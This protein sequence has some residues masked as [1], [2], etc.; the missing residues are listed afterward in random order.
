MIRSPCSRRMSQ[1]FDYP[2]VCVF[3]SQLF[4]SSIVLFLFNIFISRNW[5]SL[6]FCFCDLVPSCLLQAIY[7]I[8]ISPWQ[9][10]TS[11]ICW[12]FVSIAVF[13]VK[14]LLL[15]MWVE[16]T[17]FQSNP[18]LDR[19]PGMHYTISA[20]IKILRPFWFEHSISYRKLSLSKGKFDELSRIDCEW[21]EKLQSQTSVMEYTSNIS[22]FRLNL[23]NNEY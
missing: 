19:K 18:E 14:T 22:S 11:D 23:P 3:V 1:M 21:R 8:L 9:F 7:I 5:I 15:S 10:V 6:S 12:T 16:C 13:F 4:C 20:D 2:D 17:S